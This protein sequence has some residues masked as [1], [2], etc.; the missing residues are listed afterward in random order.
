VDEAVAATG[1]DGT[2][3]RGVN[4]HISKILED[5]RKKDEQLK[6]AV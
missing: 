4:G 5:E 1:I 2:G 3:G 6:S